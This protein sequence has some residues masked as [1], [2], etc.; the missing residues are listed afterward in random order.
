M[1]LAPASGCARCT[2]SIWG[3][4]CLLRGEI[5]QSERAGPLD[6]RECD[7]QA[8]AFTRSAWLSRSTILHMKAPR[9]CKRT[10]P[11]LSRRHSFLTV[12]RICSACSFKRHDED[13]CHLLFLRPYH[14]ELLPNCCAERRLVRERPHLLRL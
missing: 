2:L 10:I 9:S 12:R 13:S 14:A 7:Y 11:L 1:A 4:N 8:S 3:T 5:R 6:T